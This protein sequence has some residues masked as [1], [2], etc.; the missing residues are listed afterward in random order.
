MTTEGQI[1]ELDER[2]KRQLDGGATPARP[3]QLRYVLEKQLR[4]YIRLTASDAGSIK[5]GRARVQAIE[6]LAGLQRDLVGE[7][8]KGAVE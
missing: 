3:E 8:L 7:Y 4:S 2:A 5:D 6:V 1:G